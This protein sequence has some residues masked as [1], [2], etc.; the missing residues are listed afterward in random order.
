MFLNGLL[1]Y[2]SVWFSLSLHCSL[3]FSFIILAC[4]SP[5]LFLSVANN[6]KISQF[7]ECL[8]VPCV[9][10]ITH[11][12]LNKS[13]LTTTLISNK[14]RKCFSDRKAHFS[15]RMYSNYFQSFSLSFST[16]HGIKIRAQKVMDFLFF[17]YL[18]KH[19]MKC[20]ISPCG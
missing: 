6:S 15:L 3:S 18:K 1:L 4:V 5:L 13:G 20:C 14:K 2:T 9:A 17:I 8:P 11:M 10:L 19:P 7:S 12:F 16:K